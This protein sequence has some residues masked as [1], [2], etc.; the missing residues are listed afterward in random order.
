M[1]EQKRLSGDRAIGFLLAQV[2]AYA[3]GR[4]AERLGP[5]SLKPSDAGIL[6]LLGQSAGLSQQEL[7]S[8]LRIHASALVSILDDLE[9]RE[10]VQRQD[11]ATDR[12]TYAVHL[13][14]K[15]RA[16]L[17]DI[18]RISQEHNEA[19]CEPLSKQEREVLA[20]LLR[21]IA[22][23]QGLGMGIH[24]GYQRLAKRSKARQ[25]PV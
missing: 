18:A 4:F 1:P 17:A 25:E 10:L 11:S 9:T 15:G 6:R 12:R 24:P 5:L 16:T 20:D 19:L 23:G 14:D 13:T 21:R 3:A 7:A 2:G 22:E 8:R